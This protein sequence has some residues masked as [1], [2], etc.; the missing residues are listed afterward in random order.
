[1]LMKSKRQTFT[2]KKSYKNKTADECTQSI[3]EETILAFRRSLAYLY[4]KYIHSDETM[5]KYVYIGVPI[6]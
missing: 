2:N 3:W 6:I 5:Q 4:I 1:M